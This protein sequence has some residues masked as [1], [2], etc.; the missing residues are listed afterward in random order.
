MDRPATPVD[1]VDA[2][3]RTPPETAAA[4]LNPFEDETD[5]SARKRRRTSTASSHSPSR[6]S[7]R[8]DKT[9]RAGPTEMLQIRDKIEALPASSDS[10][11][12][13]NGGARTPQSLDSLAAKD[14]PGELTLSLRRMVDED[15]NNTSQREN[16]HLSTPLSL[17]SDNQPSHTPEQELTPDGDTEML[18][19]TDDQSASSDI[20][21]VITPPELFP[22]R[23]PEDELHEPVHRLALC[24][25]AGKS[26]QPSKSPTLA[27][28]GT[29]QPP[30]N[31]NYSCRSIHQ[32]QES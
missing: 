31:K 4:R 10:S 6:D 25:S 8:A 9:S 3:S 24:I 26:S 14:T 1:S 23:K 32:Y 27:D 22:F 7:S 16:E 13:T 17:A 18:V 20:Q 19:P 2:E 15:D 30:T 5:V 21:E 29:I 12:E 28:I 11:T